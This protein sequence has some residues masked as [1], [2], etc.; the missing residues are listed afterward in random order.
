M[1]DQIN[2]LKAAIE[3]HK[4]ALAAAQQESD[5]ATK[6]LED[7][8]RQEI[9]EQKRYSPPGRAAIF[10]FEP[11]SERERLEAARLQATNEVNRLAYQLGELQQML[12]RATI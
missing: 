12:K 4:Q 7:Y 6:A 11:N 8:Q 2:T 10:F 1:T 3:K 9:A 5:A